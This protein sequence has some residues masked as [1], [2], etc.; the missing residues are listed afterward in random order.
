MC[1]ERLIA[2]TRKRLDN[3]DYEAVFAQGGCFHFALRIHE[4]FGY[5]IRGIREGQ[6]GK[7]LT[8]VWCVKGDGK[9]VDIRGVYPE[10]LLAK[11]ANG[12]NPAP[13]YDVP[14]DDV[15][16]I[17]TLKG[18]PADLEREILDKADWVVDNHERFQRARPADQ[19]FYAKFLADINGTCD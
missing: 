19:G 4:R 14:V 13:F 3:H 5:P 9:G 11:L 18:Y 17:I 16:K 2:G 12:G 10:N 7:G 1:D 15:R 6:D 8:H